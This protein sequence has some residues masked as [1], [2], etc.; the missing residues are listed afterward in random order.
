MEEIMPENFDQLRNFV[1]ARRAEHRQSLRDIDNFKNR[2]HRFI[3]VPFV[4]MHA[5][6]AEK[7]SAMSVNDYLENN[8]VAMEMF[9]QNEKLRRFFQEVSSLKN[10]PQ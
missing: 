7:Q 5:R 4:S 6:V 3:S 10:T 2:R 9:L 1:A 8:T